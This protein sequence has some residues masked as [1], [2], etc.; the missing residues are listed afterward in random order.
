MNDIKIMQTLNKD[1][2]LNNDIIRQ[3]GKE[4]YLETLKYYGDE[5]GKS[6]IDTFKNEY[7][8]YPKPYLITS[9]WDKDFLN[10]EKL[11][12]GET[13]FGWDMNKLFATKSSTSFEN[14]EQIKEMM[15]YYFGYPDKKEDYDKQ[16]FYRSRGILPRIKNIC[17][18]RCRTLQP[19]HKTTQLWF[20]PV[21]NGIIKNKISAL[22]TLLNG[23]EF[24]DI[25]NT[26]HFFVAVEMDKKIDGVDNVTYMNDPHKI[27]EDIEN[28][29]KLIK[30]GKKNQ[31]NL[32]ILAGQRLQLGISLRN[33]DIVTMWNSISSSDAIFQMLF[34]SM[35]EVNIHPC[36]DKK[37]YC[38]EKKF[39]FMVDM[40]PQR[41]LMNVNLFS[42]NIDKA[43][44]EDRQKYK[45][46]TDL[47]NIDE[48]VLFDKYGDN[49]EAKEK[50]ITELMEK[51]KKSWD[52]NV[53]NIK[54]SIGTIT[55]NIEKL[56]S[57]KEIFKKIFISKPNLNLANNEEQF[58]P[59]KKKEKVGKGSKKKKEEKEI[60]I[61][62]I[63]IEIL[64][65]F[66]S[67]LNIFTLY[68]DDGSKCI[69]LT[70][71]HSQI[72]IINDIDILNLISTFN[73]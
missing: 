27:K 43:D 56:E 33:V 3:F 54:K 32:I 45:Q 47:I 36:I 60:S 9:L 23:N 70:K 72:T 42:E 73:K 35:T 11:K 69:L 12:I 2:I 8:I 29:E 15:R 17:V 26:Y 31:D 7:L 64:S 59:G 30:D 37:A 4:I 65:E 24:K 38:P 68:T 14:E 18:N 16:S 52:I 20:L 62:D 6:L 53:D 34:R 39:G 13:E 58:E 63:A 66:I 55:F 10:T 71:D 5:T 61:N 57:L 46:I 49:E 40:N 41:S 44:S 51:L 22:I 1:T 48:D 25:K 21:G 50:F 28:V 19:Q 67:L